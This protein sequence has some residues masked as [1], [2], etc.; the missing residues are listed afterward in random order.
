MN[1]DSFDP[2]FDWN[3]IKKEANFSVNQNFMQTK[4][5][6]KLKYQRK[7]IKFHSIKKNYIL[8]NKLLN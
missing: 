4:F 8:S 7:K 2:S 3:A 5:K 1:S 6:V